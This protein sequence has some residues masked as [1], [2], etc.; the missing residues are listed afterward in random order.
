MIEAEM[1]L[2]VTLL[3]R[4]IEAACKRGVEINPVRICKMRIRRI[5]GRWIAIA[6]PSPK[7]EKLALE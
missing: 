4:A 2:D 5:K 6:I 3:E 1:S 7:L